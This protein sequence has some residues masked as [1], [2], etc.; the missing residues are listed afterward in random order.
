MKKIYEQKWGVHNFET[1]PK[2]MMQSKFHNE[3]GK[4]L[5]V[6]VNPQEQNKIIEHFYYG[7]KEDEIFYEVGM[8]R[9][10]KESLEILNNF[11]EFE[12][13]V[14]QLKYTL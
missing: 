14:S 8:K 1:K 9:L 2:I 4:I 5:A 6:I 13:K 12:A 7:E 10:K 3:F 11:I